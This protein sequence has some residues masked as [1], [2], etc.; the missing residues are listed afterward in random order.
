MS[1]ATKA[2]APAMVGR[3]SYAAR[4]GNSRRIPGLGLML[5]TIE[6][7]I[8]TDAATPERD[9][10]LSRASDLSARAWLDVKEGL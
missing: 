5:K 10:E 8:P 1:P 2:G 7:T 9:K 6:R 4:L 3:S